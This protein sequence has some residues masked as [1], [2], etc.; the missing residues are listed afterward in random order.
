MEAGASISYKI[1]VVMIEPLERG[2]QTSCQIEGEPEL[3]PVLRRRPDRHVRPQGRAGRTICQVFESNRLEPARLIA[4][5]TSPLP[6]SEGP[7][8]P[9]SWIDDVFQNRLAGRP[10]THTNAAVRWLQGG[11]LE[12][13]QPT[14]PDP[15]RCLLAIRKA[16][17]A[18]AKNPDDWVAY[19]LL[20]AAYRFLAQA[21]TALLS[22]IPLDRLNHAG[23]RPGAQYRCPRHA[24]Q[25]TGHVAQLCDP[26]HA[27]AQDP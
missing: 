22:G 24:V 27:A 25:T 7:P 4:H 11:M 23:S 10:Q 1:S 20:D 26:D 6:P 19:R 3:D 8:T 13:D 18:L 17:P 2:A 9:T 15:A 16:R 14:L 12:G 5:A 21:E